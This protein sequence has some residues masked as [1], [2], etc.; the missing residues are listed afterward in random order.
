MESWE[1]VIAPTVTRGQRAKAENAKPHHAWER[2]YLLEF[3]M[4]HRAEGD[5][6]L[7]T[8]R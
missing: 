4:G 8:P 2:S 3:T 6:L 7:H 1:T 5:E